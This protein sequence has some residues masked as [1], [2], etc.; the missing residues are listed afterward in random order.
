[1]SMEDMRRDIRLV[2]PYGR[3]RQEQRDSA[4][5]R[6]SKQEPLQ[7]NRPSVHAGYLGWARAQP[8]MCCFRVCTQPMSRIGWKS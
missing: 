5:L 3:E 7:P 2:S 8:H 4:M 1:M 6:Q